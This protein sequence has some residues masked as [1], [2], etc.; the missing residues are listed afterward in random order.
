[1]AKS[2]LT[3]AF[4]ELDLLDK[5]E[6]DFDKK[7]A[8]EL[9]K[10]KE[11]DAFED[12]ETVIDP[13]AH[14]EDELQD[15]YIGMGILGCDVCHSMIYKAPEEIIIDEESHM[16]NVGEPCP[17]CYETDG[18]KIIGKV[19]PFEE[20][21]VEITDKKEDKEEKPEPTV[22]VDGKD[23]PVDEAP[24]KEEEA[25]TAEQKYP[26]QSPIAES[27]ENTRDDEELEEAKVN[28]S[29]S[30]RE[31]LL[32]AF[33]ELNFDRPVGESV[34]N[35]L[36]E[37]YDE[38]ESF[39]SQSK[40]WRLVEADGEEAT[41]STDAT[42]AQSEK[43]AG[44]TTDNNTANTNTDAAE[45]QKLV[46]ELQNIDD[47]GQ[48]VAAL[49]KLNEDQIL[50]FMTNFGKNVK[51]KIKPQVSEI[52]IDVKDLIPT[53]SEIDWKKSLDGIFQYGCKGAFSNPASAGAPP[54]VYNGKY[55]IDG[56][57]RWSQVYACNPNAKIKVINYTYGKKDP[58][59][60]LKDF[61]GAVLAA[62]GQVKEGSAGTNVWGAN[63]T[64]MN[65][66]VLSKMPDSVLKE[67]NS[68]VSK[69]TT[70]GQAANYFVKNLAQLAKNNKPYGG[71][72][73]PERTEMPQTSK[74]V[75]DLV[76]GSGLTSMSE[77]HNISTSQTNLKEGMEDISITTE[78][79]VI[80]VK[81]T[82]RADKEEIE[83]I[84]PA[85]LE[86][87]QEE[88][89]PIDTTTDGEEEVDVE[90]DEIDSESF[91]ELGESYL[92]KVYDN[93]NSFETTDASLVEN[94]LMLEGVI[95][96]ASGKKAKTKFLFE[97]KE[98]TKKGKIKFIGENVNLSK[99]K[100]AFTLTGTANKGNLICEQLNYNYLAKDEKGASKRL[101]GT[102]RKSK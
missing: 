46:D 92:K 55:I 36:K 95:E 19:A 10:F 63:A 93:V 76:K 32:R 97:G 74:E 4:E 83:P 11:D 26:V 49:K 13:N 7:G 21:S 71:A 9:A 62:T 8:E 90:L 40:R 39:E 12:F 37:Y 27:L 56:H 57:H 51:D 30:N 43:T 89:A 70:K 54:L 94:K 96:F 15:S 16:A 67:L 14:S 64:E 61:Q 1:M 79:Q 6:F 87:A 25:L 98:M 34:E 84:T 23:V 65:K 99:N 48:F 2:Y 68:Y 69:I 86:K 35:G 45:F 100:R 101:Y 29:L 85:E 44:T 24:E 52:T 3:E 38:D 41:T 82:P 28:E 91:D 73:A 22:K 18:F 42:S 77:A 59:D 81:A 88:A 102:V 5:G 31:K 20:V 50:L 53:Q 17:Y 75:T 66:H 47:Y 78:D 58:D 60:V 80:K 72:N 33:P